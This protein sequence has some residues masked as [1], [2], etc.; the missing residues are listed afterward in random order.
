MGCKFL[1]SLV[2]FKRPKLEGG[3]SKSDQRVSAL[4]RQDIADYVEMMQSFGSE[5]DET[6]LGN[7]KSLAAQAS[8]TTHEIVLMSIVQDSKLGVAE[9]QQKIKQQLKQLQTHSTAFGVDI[10][11][12]MH[13]MVLSVA[14]N[15]AMQQR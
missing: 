10:R 5:P 9:K 13:P 6:L 3:V 14:S 7:A 4:P 12:K 1:L 15:L 11:S 8:E 2:F